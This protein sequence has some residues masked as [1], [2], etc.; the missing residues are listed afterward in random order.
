MT[1]LYRYC[2]IFILLFLVQ[3]VY[4]QPDASF[5]AS[6]TSGCAPLSVQF[7]SKEDQYTHTWDFG[8]APP[9]NNATPDPTR[10]YTQP[11][12]Y[13]VV[14]T[15]S[16]P[17]GTSSKST[18][19][20]VFPTP[21]IDFTATSTNVCP[22][23]AV[24]FTYNGNLGVAGSANYSWVLGNNATPATAGGTGVS[25]VTTSYSAAGKYNVTLSVTNSK[26]C[27]ASITKTQ[28]ITVKEQPIVDFTASQTDFCTDTGRVTFTPNITGG[29]PG[30]YIYSWQ[31]GGPSNPTSNVP[32]P[33]HTYPGPAPAQYTVSLSVK[34]NNGCSTSVTKNNY[35]RL[36]KPQAAFTGPSSACV[37][38][39]VTFTNGSPTTGATHTWDFG[40]NTGTVNSLN[41]NHIYSS[42]GTYTVTLTTT[43]GGC[44]NVAT[45]TIVIHPQPSAYIKL[46]PDSV[47]PAP[48][49]I[50]FS[51]VPA[52]SSYEWF[53]DDHLGTYNSTASSPCHTYTKDGHYS[54]VSV[55][56]NGNGCKDTIVK[57]VDIHE[58]N[59]KMTVNNNY[60]APPAYSDSGCVAFPAFFNV[61]IY[62]DS[63]KIYPYGVKSYK[64][65]FGNGD[66][67]TVKSPYYT[68]TTSGHFRVLVIV[69]TNN[70]CIIKDSLYI[71]TGVK[72]IIDS[73][74]A[75]D[76][77]ICPRSWVHFTSHVRGID[78]MIYKWDFGDQGKVTRALDST[79][80]HRYYGGPMCQDTFTIKL[81]VSHNG[82]VSDQYKKEDY[83]K[84][85]PPC[86]SWGYLLDSCD[87]P[88]RVSFK[89]YSRGDSTRMWYFGDGDSS[90]AREPV[91]IYATSGRYY[92][93]LV[94]YNSI[95][96]CRDTMDQMIF[97]GDN[98]P[99]VIANKTELCTGDS[100]EFFA[101]LVGDTAQAHF[102]W[103]INGI[104]VN[105][106][107]DV[108]RQVF[109]N[110]GQYTVM[111][112]SINAYTQCPDTVIKNNWITVGR[113]TAG[114]KT[115]KIYVCNPDSVLFTDTSF[116]GAGT[117]IAKR[118]WFFGRSLN[119]TLTTSSLTH[120]KMYANPGDYDIGLII[121][122]NLGCAD[123][124]YRQKYLHA[125]KPIADFSVQSPVCVG[126]EAS[127]TDA[128]INAIKYRWHFGDGGI[129]TTQAN[130]K[131]I[132][133]SIGVFNTQLIVTDSIGCKDTSAIIP[134][135]ATKPIANFTM[136]DSMSVCA[137]LIVNFSGTSSIRAFKYLWHFDDGS[138]PGYKKTH[139][140][141]YND[142]KEYKVKL[143][144]EDSLGCKDSI[145]KPIQVLG[146][147]GAF[148]YDTT[149]G[150]APL[151]VNFSL[152]VKGSIPTIIWDFGDGNSLL[153]NYQ[154]PNVTYT[155]RTPGKYLPRMIF[156][157]GL[158]CKVGSD[159]LD[160]IVVDG[161]VADFETG[162]AC[163]YSQVEFKN[164]SYT[165]ES[166]I[167]SYNWKFHDGSF[168]ALKD[169]KRKYGAPGKYNVKLLAVSALGCRDSVERDITIHKPIELNTGGDTIICLKDSAQLF[170][171]GGVSY[172]WSPGATLSC[173]QCN[174]PFASP[175][176]KTTYTVISTDVNGCHDT[177][178]VEVDIKTHVESI[179]GEGGKICEGETMTLNVSGA[180]TYLWSPAAAIDDP[181]SASPKVNP[182]Q[183]TQF[184]VVAFE[185]SCIPDTSYAEVIVHPKPT[186]SVRGE[187]TI[188]AGT[189]ADLLAS[190]NNI[191]RF[192]WSPVNTL[193]CT[194]CANPIASPFKT[195]IYQVK[196]FTLYDCVDSADVK[197][198]VL[199]DN[200][201]LFIPNTFTPNGD[202]MNDIFMVRG[203]GI[204]TLKSFRIYN[205]WG[206]LM[207]ERLNAS[208]NE[209]QSGWDGTFNGAQLPPDV[210]VYMVEAYCENGDLLK[211]KGD[212]T[213]IR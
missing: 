143:I 9:I 88:L 172:L 87:N 191:V 132:Y 59:I 119:D 6:P 104:K 109:N 123:T 43:I 213:I 158:G 54:V 135:Q 92:V 146:Y 203:A 29:A 52:M 53:Y 116:A 89:N 81:N 156:N 4:A 197:I 44:A 115:D 30:P 5:T 12:T 42:A 72:P 161:V 120:K 204:S 171:S 164:K 112:T 187:Q 153:G 27:Y 10:S 56:T 134:V 142:V 196:V 71:K 79:A 182:V 168:S 24:T 97:F 8:N 95:S 58:L 25:S 16:G 110:P 154:N 68:Y 86:A 85:L 23:E 60:V 140:V 121:T 33:S 108:H 173:T 13:T 118:K 117:N 106:V 67:S 150:C 98:Y 105:T 199:C 90:S 159:G 180:R 125:L 165:V 65:Y 169:P 137:P 19:I 124:V 77:I 41:G 64:W 14:H 201:Q 69:E 166:P 62:R 84:M 194:D 18:T 181:T 167:T 144:V 148:E 40:D 208:V 38:T 133:K 32:A 66:S 170:P 74:K 176:K 21:T 47:C 186:V 207:F 94:A 162:P 76:T 45:K 179:V 136:S 189:T 20:T 50:C 157:N 101:F 126:G 202:G 11:G 107:T 160:T 37:F 15:I 51:T 78:T 178:R 36:H 206:E 149:Q 46:T 102:D 114:F 212:I 34:S 152:N 128:S 192:L 1:Y 91:H 190:G 57:T 205:R 83:I 200:S 139:T 55:I 141:V 185:G 127:F 163:Q 49:M 188:V 177:D 195:T 26:N 129:D 28:Y 93:R 131:H 82:C 2:T 39:P 111:V 99:D 130:P 198:T 73:I 211:V 174:N 138:T 122:D 70:G 145:T 63:G 48:Q 61:N 80:W 31:L 209:K 75:S 96:K 184:R 103:F 147:A 7:D 35:I 100:V 193:S 22:N 3:D 151:T 17:G 175:E 155:Y 183:T 113:P 210:Y